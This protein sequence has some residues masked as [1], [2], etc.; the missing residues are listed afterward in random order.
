MFSISDNKNEWFLVARFQSFTKEEKDLDFKDLEEK[1]LLLNKE[2]K[3][4][5]DLVE[6]GFKNSNFQ[7]LQYIDGKA[8]TGKK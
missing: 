6:N 3:S 7:I 4:V 5:L 8:S 2:L 1:K